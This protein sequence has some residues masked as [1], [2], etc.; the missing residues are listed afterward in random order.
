[1]MDLRIT[2]LNEEDSYTLPM[3]NILMNIMDIIVKNQ[4][5]IYSLIL[6]NILIIIIIVLLLI[7]ARKF[8]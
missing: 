2:I 6:V 8:V 7:M 3:A 1:M 4:P 5:T